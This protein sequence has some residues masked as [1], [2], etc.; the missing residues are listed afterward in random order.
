MTENFKKKDVAYP[1]EAQLP[2]M[3]KKDMRGGYAES[4]WPPHDRIEGPPLKEKPRSRRK[5]VSRT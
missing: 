5:A 3:P 4:G 2:P 1:A